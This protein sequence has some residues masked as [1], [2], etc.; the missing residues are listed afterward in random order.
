MMA[1]M[2]R[3]S[4]ISATNLRISLALLPVLLVASILM[5]GLVALGWEEDLNLGLSFD[6]T[7]DRSVVCVREKKGRRKFSPTL[8]IWETFIPLQWQ[9]AHECKFGQLPDSSKTGRKRDRQWQDGKKA[10]RLNEGKTFCWKVR[11][12]QRSDDGTEICPLAAK[13]QG[14]PVCQSIIHHGSEG[15]RGIYRTRRE[16]AKDHTMGPKSGSPLPRLRFTK[17]ITRGT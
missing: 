4:R 10:G 1:M 5:I 15:T 9:V 3:T 7:S 14:L 17:C 8:K 12:N 2:A 11:Q 6:E 13:L 16:R